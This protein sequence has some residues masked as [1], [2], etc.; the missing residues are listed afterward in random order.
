MDLLLF[1]LAEVHRLV[2]EPSLQL[3]ILHLFFVIKCGY[4]VLL[5]LNTPLVSLR[6]RVLL[7]LW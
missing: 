6:R 3:A 1:G 2:A 7:R 4:E 5:A